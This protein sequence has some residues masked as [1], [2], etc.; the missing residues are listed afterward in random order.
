M[1]GSISVDPFLLW[2]GVLLAVATVEGCACTHA[3]GGGSSLPAAATSVTSDLREKALAS[4]G[5][6]ELV[7]SLTDEVGPRLAGSTGSKAAVEWAMRAFAERGFANVH[8]EPVT[9]PRW[10]RGEENLSLIH[11]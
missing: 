3:G 6:A 2:A 10:E 1:S 8:T 9:V 5:A 4:R 11:I 7:R